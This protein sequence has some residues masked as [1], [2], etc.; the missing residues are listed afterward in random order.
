[1]N[2]KMEYRNKGSTEYNSVP[3]YREICIMDKCW[4]VIIGW[5]ESLDLKA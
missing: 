2:V 3:L 5:Y 1:M 4:L